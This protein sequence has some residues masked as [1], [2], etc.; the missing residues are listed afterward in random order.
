MSHCFTVIHCSTKLWD[1]SRGSSGRWQGQENFMLRL[2]AC[3]DKW[4]S[5]LP[6]FV[7]LNK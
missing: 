5:S 2:T 4:M 3:C 7:P 1:D 6:R